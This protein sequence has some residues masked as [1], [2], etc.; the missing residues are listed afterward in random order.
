VVV[1]DLKSNSFLFS[2]H[3]SCVQAFIGL[4]ILC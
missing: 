2:P 3:F 1:G 4:I